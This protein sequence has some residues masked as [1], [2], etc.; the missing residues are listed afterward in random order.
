MIHPCLMYN[1]FSLRITPPSY[2][3]KCLL[4]QEENTL[5]EDILDLEDSMYERHVFALH[6]S[7]RVSPVVVLCGETQPSRKTFTGFSRN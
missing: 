3:M 1:I 4:N 2:N 5:L 6:V 7:R